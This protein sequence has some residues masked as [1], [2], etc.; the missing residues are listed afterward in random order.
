MLLIPW[1][2]F[3]IDSSG[4]VKRMA[5]AVGKPSTQRRAA[6]SEDK[7]STTLSFLVGPSEPPLSELTLGQ[8][9]KKQAE[10]GPLRPCL[11]FSEANY[12]VTYGELY[13]CTLKVAKGLLAAGVQNGD[14]IGIFAGNVP[15]YVELFFAASHVGASLVVFNTT[16]TPLELKS[17]LEHSGSPKEHPCR[18]Q[19]FLMQYRM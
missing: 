5:N 9:L 6:E 11:V 7:A 18:Y 2:D 1:G 8:L 14:R 12:R 4:K 17:A 16:Y 19:K 10:V 13:T 15:A 3:S